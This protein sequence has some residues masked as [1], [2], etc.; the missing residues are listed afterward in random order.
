[1]ASKYKSLAALGLST[2]LLGGLVA[3]GNEVET[4]PAP[5]E[6]AAAEDTDTAATQTPDAET[7]TSSY[8]MSGGEGEGDGGEGEGGEGEGGEGGV[9]LTAAAEDPAVYRS[10]L[11]M[12]E[13]HIRAGIDALDAGERRAAGE[14]FAHPVSEILLDFEPVLVQQGVEPFAQKLS[15]ASAAVFAEESAEDLRARADDIIETLR[16][17]AEKAPEGSDSEAV[18]EAK[19][20]ADQIDRATAQYD[21]ASRTDAYE[22]YLDGYGFYNT[23]NAL[24]EDHRA[25]I[26]A[27][28]PEFVEQADA[29]LAMLADAYPTANRPDT[30]DADQS[31][32]TAGNSELQLIVSGL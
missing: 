1:M 17:A 31:A 3:C 11:A 22:P 8:A 23:A 28:A 27:D 5:T 13:A 15:D 16:A 24:L 26:E 10:A 2:T 4:A 18:V 19:V 6:T 21:S 25:D 32:M 7:D 12:T 30:L 29:V 9:D 20:I 14:M